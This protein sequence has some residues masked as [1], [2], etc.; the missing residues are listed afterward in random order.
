[1]SNDK[2]RRQSRVPVTRLGRV[3][4]LGLAAGE[5]AVGGLTE[6]VR[7]VTGVEPADAVNVFLTAANAQK[8]AKRLAGMRGAAMK[9]GQILSME[10]ADILPPQFTEA[11]AIL[12]DSA[13]TMPDSQ[14]RRVMGREY[15]KGWEA[16]FDNFDFE[17]IAA[18]SVM[19]A[20]RVETAQTRRNVQPLESPVSVD[21]RVGMGSTTPGG[22]PG[23]GR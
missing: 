10:G 17:P 7:R 23:D 4:R 5:L 11:L 22:G 6:G 2:T 9:L 15:G 3:L 21:E 14:V 1:M 20:S 18:A 13:D 19:N 16:R 8:L 12:R